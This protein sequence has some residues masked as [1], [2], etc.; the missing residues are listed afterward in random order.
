MVN[1]G[2]VIR[3]V[4]VVVVVLSAYPGNYSALGEEGRRVLRAV[5][6]AYDDWWALKR[7][8]GNCVVA[9]TVLPSGD[10]HNVH[11]FESIQSIEEEL[12]RVLRSAARLWRFEPQEHTTVHRLV[13]VFRFL[14][15]GTP[16]EELGFVFL[17]PT[18]VEIRRVEPPILWLSDVPR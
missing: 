13:F 6:P 4:L 3:R 16:P 7:A 14:P 8:Q 10:V 5:A 11:V 15:E 2:I 9:V 17:A 12:N 18:T 1:G